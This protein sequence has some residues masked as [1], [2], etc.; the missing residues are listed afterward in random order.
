VD[1]L[2]ISPTAKMN[3]KRTVASLAA[4]LLALMKARGYSTV[5][6]LTFIKAR[7]PASPNLHKAPIFQ[8]VKKCTPSETLLMAA[9][10]PAERN[11]NKEITRENLLK[12]T[13]KLDDLCKNA[14]ILAERQVAK[15]WGWLSKQVE[16]QT[17]LP[18]D[19]VDFL[20]RAALDDQSIAPNRGQKRQRPRTGPKAGGHS[21]RLVVTPLGMQPFALEERCKKENKFSMIAK[22]APT[23]PNAT[24][25][26]SAKRTKL[27]ECDWSEIC[28]DDEFC[29]VFLG[30]QQRRGGGGGGP[31][32]VSANIKYRGGLFRAPR[33]RPGALA[34]LGLT[35]GGGV[36][37]PVNLPDL[38]IRPR[39]AASV[40]G[41]Q[42]TLKKLRQ[43]VQTTTKA[44]ATSI[45][46][47]MNDASYERTIE[48]SKDSTKIEN[49]NDRTNNSS[50]NVE[51]PF[52]TATRKDPSPSPSPSP[53]AA[54]PFKVKPTTTRGL[55]STAKMFSSLV[56]N[57]SSCRAFKSDHIAPEVVRELAE[58]TIRA[59]TGF[60]AQP[61]KVIFVSDPE[62]RRA[63]GSCMLGGSNEARVISAPLT[64]VFLADKE[65]LR[66]QDKVLNVWRAE[67]FPEPFL[68]LARTGLNV[69]SG[70]HGNRFLRWLAFT[71]KSIAFRL[72][73]IVGMSLPQVF[74]AGV[75]CTK[76]TM[77]PASFYLLAC[78]SHGL[79]TAPMEGFDARQL[80]KVLKIPKRY[81]IPL[82]VPTGYADTTSD[83][84]KVSC[85]QRFE[86]ADMFYMDGFGQM[87]TN[88]LG[89]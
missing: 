62:V 26:K 28:D 19:L 29:M 50:A 54:L 30:D 74:T 44:T 37:Q 41:V 39:A 8:P 38:Q 43:K 4:V 40:A 52:T 17:K 60:N 63:V 85:S 81:N 21:E 72:L 70:G 34:P 86:L 15:S 53:A 73:S 49:G 6:S 80:R 45:H 36:P 57:R 11:T 56:R 83:F 71:I 35:R 51:R 12:D 55:P 2:N 67:G 77:I 66:D 10:G 58:V 76:N 84:R 31:E 22:T 5:D 48:G 68:R 89:Q 87:N 9:N 46:A 82:V 27:D 64:A 32:A 18:E 33:S 75:W 1:F 3:L 65:N 79:G 59:P 14:Y 20:A 16:N 61:Y 78:Q 24:Q 42:N 13:K 47:A 23:I 7:F 69:F 25:K 88:V